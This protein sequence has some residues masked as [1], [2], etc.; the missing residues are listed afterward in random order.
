MTIIS[1][2]T[3]ACVVKL[4]DTLDS[5]S[6]DASLGGSIPPAGTTYNSLKHVLS[7]LKF[8]N[9]SIKVSMPDLYR[10]YITYFDTIHD[11]KSKCVP[12]T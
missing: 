9:V 8:Q 2:L 7:R 11:L 12:N 4:V 5:K 3:H 6:S 1:S 10:I